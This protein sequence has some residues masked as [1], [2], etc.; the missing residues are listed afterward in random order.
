MDATILKVVR[1]ALSVLAE[2]LLIIL[3]LAMSFGL[4][5]WSMWDPM[6]GRLI[7]LGLFA[8]LVYIPLLLKGKKQNDVNE[9]NS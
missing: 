7:T 9:E 5:C 8:I 4:A 6:N 1:V 2:R 3:G